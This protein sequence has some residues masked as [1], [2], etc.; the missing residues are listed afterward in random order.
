M[1]GYRNGGRIPLSETVV[2]TGIRTCGQEPADDPVKAKMSTTRSTLAFSIHQTIAKVGDDLGRRHTF[3]TAIAAVMELMNALGKLDDSSRA[4][5]NLMQEALEKTY[6]CCRPSCLTSVMRYGV[7]SDR[8]PNSLINAGRKPIARLW[9]SD[10]IKLVVQVNGNLPARYVLPAIQSAKLSSVSHWKATRWRNSS[11]EN[12]EESGIGTGPI[13]EYRRL[14]I[15]EPYL[16]FNHEKYLAGCILFRTLC[17]RLSV[18]GQ[19]SLPFETLFISF[20]AGPY[21]YRP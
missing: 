8:V 6:C 5:R 11:P 1:G 17:V 15:F 9:C 21:W 20:P 12:S 13:G 7:N 3:N 4:A 2:E 16:G 14:R 19:A 18:A 10:E